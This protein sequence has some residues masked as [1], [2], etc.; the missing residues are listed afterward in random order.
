MKLTGA[1][2]TAFQQGL[3]S[4]HARRIEQALSSKAQPLGSLKPSLY[5]AA[6]MLEPNQILVGD[7][8]QMLNDGPKAGPTW[9]SPTR[10]STSGT[11]TTATT[12]S[13]T[14]TTT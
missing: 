9:C 13:G 1:R 2:K 12:T 10:R 3:K 4:L 14:P 6:G 5:N 8:I 7:S 11:C